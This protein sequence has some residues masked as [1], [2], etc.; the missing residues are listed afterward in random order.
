[1]TN[2]FQQNVIPP[3]PTLKTNKRIGTE[4]KYGEEIT[5]S[6]RLNELKENASK[7]TAKKRRINSTIGTSTTS[8]SSDGIDT[9]TTTAKR[10]RKSTKQT[11]ETIIS[12]QATRAIIT[13]QS[14]CRN[15]DS[16]Q[17]G[18]TSPQQTQQ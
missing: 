4:A 3:P 1:V 15:I 17:I 5:S 8:A 10:R 9:T 18:N 16:V 14:S 12:S 7:S 11:S 2:L 6:N 13:L